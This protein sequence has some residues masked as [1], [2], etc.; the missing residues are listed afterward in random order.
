MTGADIFLLIFFIL[1]GLGVALYFLNKWAYKKMGEQQTMIE[2]YKTTVSIYVIEKMK[3]KSDEVNLPKAVTSQLTVFYKYLKMP[4]V[5]AKIGPQ[6]MTLMCDKKVFEA[7]PVKKN[8]KVELA[9]IYIV[10]MQGMKTKAELKR[11]AKSKKAATKSD[12][13]YNKAIDRIKAIKPA[14]NN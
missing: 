14:K 7:L 2:K 3:A 5:K 8:V 1:A 6:I 13:W 4:Y 11:I 10:S 9:G 12:A